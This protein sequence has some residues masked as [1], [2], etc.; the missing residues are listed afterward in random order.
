M[1]QERM[2]TLYTL[3]IWYVKP[4][5]EDEFYGEWKK[6]AEWTK[7]HH[8]GARTAVL[9]EDLAEKTRFVSLGPWDSGGSID[10]WRNSPEFKEAFTKFKQLCFDIQPHTMRCVAVIGEKSGD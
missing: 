1:E 10:A 5:K 9:L 8:P 3:G 2:G 6:F 4:G 7:A